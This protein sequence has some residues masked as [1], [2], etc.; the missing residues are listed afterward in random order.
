VKAFPDGLGLS[1][2]G[3]FLNTNLFIEE[4]T[5]DIGIGTTDP[6]ARLTLLGTI[7]FRDGIS[8]LLI[9]SQTGNQNGT[10]MFWGHSAAFPNWGIFYNDST[11]RMHFRQSFGN[12]FA[13][14]DFPNKRVGIGTATNPESALHVKRNDGSAQVRVEEASTTTADR[15][16][17]NLRNKGG[18]FARILNTQPAPDAFWDIGN[19]SNGNFTVNANGGSPVDLRLTPAGNL[20]IAGTLTQGSDRNLK[21]AIREVR[22]SEVLRRLTELPIATWRYRADRTRARHIGP[23]AQDFADAFGFG[24][25]RRS[26]APGDVGGVALAAIKALEAENRDLKR[27]VAALEKEG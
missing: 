8:P 26:L 12:E 24:S 15:T 18:T 20:T 2:G 27:R 4:T 23:M 13:T 22:P 14:F 11:D 5:G 3:E 7:G 19:N 21:E 9:N 25:D 17:L 16:L 6:Y 1:G 10:R